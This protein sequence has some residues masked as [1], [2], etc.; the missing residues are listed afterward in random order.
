MPDRFSLK[1]S[2]QGKKL[3][4]EAWK[5][6]ILKH[7]TA[8]ASAS[9]MNEI[10]LQEASKILQ[11]DKNWDNVSEDHCAISEATLKRF[12]EAK[13]RITAST[14][15]TFCKVLDLNWEDVAE[16]E[17]DANRDLS[18]APPPISFYGRTQ[19]LAE[20]QECLIQKGCRLVLI[21]GMGGVGKSALVRHLVD[22]IADKYNRLLWVSLESAPP[23]KK[24]LNR[25][26][27]FLSK[28]EQEE[29]DIYQL[30]Q[31][32]H[33][34]KCLIVLDAWEEI[35]DNH[36]EDY[37]NYNVFVEKVAKESHKSSL[38]LLSRRKPDNIAILEGKFVFSKKSLPL[39]KKD[40]KE[41][42]SAEGLFGTDIE[43]EKFSERY[44]NPW[45]LKRIIQSIHNV[46]NGDISP[47]INNGEVTT[48]IDEL[49][50]GFLNQQFKRLS[51]AEINL[52]YWVGIR[53][54]TA[55]WNHL[56]QDSKHFITY[57]QLFETLNNLIER[58]SLISKNTEEV[59]L[60]YI[61]EPIVLKYINERFIAENYAQ[62]NQI[63]INEIINGCEL[64]I[65]HGFITGYPKDEELNQE[66]MRR[67]VKPIE[68]MLL[69]NFR[70]QQQLENQLKKVLSLLEEKGLSQRY[71]SQ[72]ISHLISAG[73]QN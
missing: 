30:M 33:H 52:I 67:I 47:F 35:M 72:N 39:M 62:I 16:N 21:H 36:S 25:L 32:L 4:K 73:K 5:R 64:F 45:I 54:N 20:L 27:Q 17:A 15:N 23:F 63:F 57:Q 65:T 60:I 48:V 6:L 19:E 1:A 2:Q 34:Q 13:V 69:A 14:F 55:L 70:S 42:L 44:N 26:V 38:F 68:K 59:S 7:G 28:G 3:I 66:Q 43:L 56:V 18:E 9:D 24:I 11:P 40:V 41:F 51:Q 12:R 49:T 58:H 8:I 22:T 10:F 37:T 50:T 31:Y 46:F 53:R 71:A 61:L 29:G